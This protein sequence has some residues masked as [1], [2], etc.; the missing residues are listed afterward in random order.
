MSI[1][2]DGSEGTILERLNNFKITLF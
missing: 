1:K 2:T